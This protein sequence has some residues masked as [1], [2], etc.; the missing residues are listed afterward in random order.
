MRS[1]RNLDITEFPETIKTLK[2]FSISDVILNKSIFGVSVLMPNKTK[3]CLA[4]C[5]LFR[6]D[7]RAL[8]F[9]GKDTHCKFAD[10]ICDPKSCKFARCA[11]GRL[12][13]NG[14]C[15]IEAPTKRFE[16]RFDD[17]E[18]PIN[19]PGKLAQKVK[20]KEFY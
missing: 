10:D 4:T 9:K 6:C 3:N 7:Q 13:S 16:L 5:E 2:D 15:N 11:K 20:D 12:L 18:G 19:L 8:L 17:I 14:S 1:K